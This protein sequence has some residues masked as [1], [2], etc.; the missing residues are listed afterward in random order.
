MVMIQLFLG[1]RSAQYFG[2]YLGYSPNYCLLLVMDSITAPTVQGYQN[3]TLILGSTHI[4]IQPDALSVS[5]QVLKGGDVDPSKDLLSF[6]NGAIR[7]I[8]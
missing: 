7:G 3:E 1:G 6:F 4:L 8:I 5:W 2:G